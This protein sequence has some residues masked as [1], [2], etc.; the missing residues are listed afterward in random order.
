MNNPRSISRAM[1]ETLEWLAAKVFSEIDKECRFSER[2]AEVGMGADGTP[3]CRIDQVAEEI[4]LRLMDER[5]VPLNVLSEEAG[6]IDRGYDR[7]LVMDPVDGT[8]NALMGIPFYS[9]S[10][11]V[12]TMSMND[13]TDAIVRNLV[14][15]DT[16]K[17]IKGKGATWNGRTIHV[18]DFDPDNSV[19]MVYLG[20]FC[21]PASNAIVHKARRTR[22][23]GCSSMEMCLVAAGL[24]DG[25][26]MNSKIYK[27]SLRVVDIAASA[28]ILREAGGEIYDLDDHILDMPLDLE[29][30]ANCLAVGDPAV[31]RW[32]R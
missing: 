15:G 1:M 6:L 9:V 26:Y 28:L 32:I 18:R 27:R 19:L 20:K 7:T 17:A 16:F 13:A 11:A 4:L 5:S 21:S 14:T 30:R 31:A 2:S 24:A 23:M 25:Y 22:S 12:C 29:N 3:T 8:Y 10:L